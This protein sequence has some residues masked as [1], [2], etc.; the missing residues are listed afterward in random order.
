MAYPQADIEYDVYTYLLHRAQMANG[1]TR[2]HVLRLLKNA[3][4]Q[5]QADILCSPNQD[6]TDKAIKDLKNAKFDIEHK[7]KVEVYL[8]TTIMRLP[9]G[10]IVITQSQI[11]QSMIDEVP[12]PSNLKNEGSP[13][14]TIKLF[15]RYT[16]VLK[17]GS[18]ETLAVQ[19]TSVL[20]YMR[21]QGRPMYQQWII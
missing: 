16:D 2:S 14:S 3:Y 7:G 13:V 4:G 6:D 9:G 18:E 11:I 21:N 1:P 12:L 5:N 8:E 15:T 19:L 20:G 17:K 10:R